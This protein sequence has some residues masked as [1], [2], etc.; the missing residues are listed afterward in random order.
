VPGRLKRTQA[1]VVDDLRERAEAVASDVAFVEYALR[2][3]PA[4]AAGERDL[5]HRTKT[6]PPR[7]RE[8]LKS[9]L[10]DGRATELPGVG[11]IHRRRA[12]E[13][14]QRLLAAAE[15]Y[16][17]ASPESP[18]QTPEAIF[19]AAGIARPIGEALAARLVAAGK[20]ASRS[21]RLALASH[22][23]AVAAED[24]R[25]IDAIERAFL[26]RPFSPPDAAGAAA[27][28]K[29]S[30]DRA[31]KAVRLLVEQQR[32]VEIAPDLLMHRDA[33]ARARQM[34]TDYIRKEGCLESVKFKYLLETT[35][36]FAIPLLD[37]FD[38]IGLT[39]ASGHT[40]YLRPQKPS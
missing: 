2:T 9:L 3:A 7:V 6:L 15:A 35:R 31:A 38:R 12:E 27:A 18:G 22:R 11:F 4:V 32:L 26:G 10:A 13:A 28:A 33:I 19:E 34:L 25:A 30:A 24:Q 1:G 40:R 21:G 23:P 36:K 8:I 20:M 39:R 16:H 17:R 5:A 37:Y 29:V 14:E